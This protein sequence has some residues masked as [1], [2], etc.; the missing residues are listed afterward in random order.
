MTERNRLGRD[1]EIVRADRLAVLFKTSSK[2]AIG[3]IGRRVER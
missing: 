3:T 2:Q 1:E